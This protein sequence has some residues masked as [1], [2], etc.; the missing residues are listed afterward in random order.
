MHTIAHRH[1]LTVPQA[2]MAVHG[3]AGEQSQVQQPPLESAL[4]A[5]CG[6]AAQG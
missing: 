1:V 5:A 6:I 3:L 4:H 2:H